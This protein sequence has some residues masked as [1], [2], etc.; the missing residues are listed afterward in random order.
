MSKNLDGCVHLADIGELNLVLIFEN[1]EFFP[2][3]ELVVFL[4]AVD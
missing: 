1:R 2:D 3:V 4:Q